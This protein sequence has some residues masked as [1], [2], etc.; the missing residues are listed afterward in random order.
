MGSRP[1]DDQLRRR[2]EALVDIEGSLEAAVARMAEEVMGGARPDVEPQAVSRPKRGDD[3]S[4]DREGEYLREIDVLQR[5]ITKLSQSLGL[6]EE[7]LRRVKQGEKLDTGLASIYRD[8]QGLNDDEPDVDPQA[9][10]DVQHLRGHMG[11]QKKG[12]G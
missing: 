6:T 8:V 12:S 2:L 4:E 10:A 5:R 3:L 1:K 7:V 9:R 11:L